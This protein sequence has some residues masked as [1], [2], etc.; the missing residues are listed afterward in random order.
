MSHRKSVWFVAGAL[1]AVGLVFWQVSNVV[2]IN[3]LLVRIEQKQRTLD[4]LQWRS[5]QEQI[6]IARLESAERIGRI[7]RQRFGM[8]TPDRPPILIRA[9]LP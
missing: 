4:S 8:Q 3:A 7:A 9:Q 1:A 2:S 5:R 6:L